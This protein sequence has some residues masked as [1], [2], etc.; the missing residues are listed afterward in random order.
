VALAVAGVAA[1]TLAAY[2]LGNRL[3]PL[4]F[5]TSAREP[6]AYAIAAGC[7]IVFA[8]LASLVPGLRAAKVDP[9][10]ALRAE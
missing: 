7:I 9:L 4:L 6:R 3:Q 5:E 8:L 2:V 1:G 10:V